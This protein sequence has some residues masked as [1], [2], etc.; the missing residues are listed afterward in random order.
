[1]V[2]D[3]Y[4][5][6][7][8]EPIGVEEGVVA[9]VVAGRVM[10]GPEETGIDSVSVP[11]E[12]VPGSLDILVGLLDEVGVVTGGIEMGT[13]TLEHWA[14]TA[15]ETAVYHVNIGFRVEKRWALTG[16]VLEVTVSLHARSHFGDERRLPAVAGKVG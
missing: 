7:D 10:G 15:F 11:G 12:V 5:T 4:G 14:V 16:L 8:N 1:V 9:G 3:E 2:A 6:D 13:P